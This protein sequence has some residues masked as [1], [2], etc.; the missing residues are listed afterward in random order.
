MMV[1]VSKGKT[2]AGHVN[3]IIGKMGETFLQKTNSLRKKKFNIFVITYYGKFVETKNVLCYTNNFFY[4]LI[5]INKLFFKC[6]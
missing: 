6:N 5:I 3:V 4:T 1:C 2:R